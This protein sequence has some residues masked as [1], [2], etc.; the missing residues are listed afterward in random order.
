[1]PISQNREKDRWKRKKIYLR[2]RVL[3]LRS[4]FVSNWA[5]EDF[6][7]WWKVRRS[8]K[9][10]IVEW[11]WG[12]GQLGFGKECI[13]GGGGYGVRGWEL[14]LETWDWE[15][16]EKRLRLRLERLESWNWEWRERRL[17]I[18]NEILNYER[19]RYCH[20]KYME[21][22]DRIE[23]WGYFNFRLLAVLILL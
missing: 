14:R 19:V 20:T 3:R 8:H 11:W 7:L 16:R 2:P 4:W 1:M 13:H 10:V 22:S 12:G 18:G 6:N 15:Q 9:P 23:H 17:I 21:K 5:W